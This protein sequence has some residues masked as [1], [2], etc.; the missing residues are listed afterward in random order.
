MW[1]TKRH[2][3]QHANVGAAGWLLTGAIHSGGR[4]G[5]GGEVVRLNIEI[6]GTLLYGILHHLNTVVIEKSTTH[7]HLSGG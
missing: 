6:A 3:K 7:Q 1:A 4:Q 5:R 2:T